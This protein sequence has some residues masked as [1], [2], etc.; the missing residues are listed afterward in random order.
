MLKPKSK[1]KKRE[2][3]LLERCLKIARE[4][5]GQP[6]APLMEDLPRAYIRAFVRARPGLKLVEDRA[7]NMLVK[8]PGRAGRRPPLVLVAH[9]DHPGFHVEKASRS[10]AR[11]AFKGGVAQA[12]AHSGLRVRFFNRGEA[13]PSG[14]GILAKIVCKR[15]RLAGA[16]ARLSAGRP[17]RGDF[18]LWDFPAFALKNGAI[19]SRGCDD[20]LGAAAALCVLDEL[21]GSTGFPACV[22][23]LF[24]RAE[25]FGFMGALEAIRLKTVPKNARIVSLECSK[26]L[27]DAP[28]GGGVI[29]RVGD[30]AGIFA[31]HLT[32][33]LH[34]AAQ[35]L[36]KTK[37]GFKS[38]RKLMDGGTCEA[39]IFCAYGYQASGLAVPLGNYHNQGFTPRGVATIK[40]EH[41]KVADFFNEIQL[42]LELARNPAWLQEKPGLP[43][44]VKVR[45]A[46][47]CKALGKEGLRLET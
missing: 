43:E 36:A 9:L 5:L 38:Q 22:Y 15:G 1:T 32:E 10:A 31:P 45:A 24:T 37:R 26:A 17:A 35:H 3:K 7:G 2:L 40:P 12:H 13:A 16:V 33:A 19:V 41:V 21:C 23:A 4:L 34:R 20:P 28:Q 46:N 11:L 44:W 6:A 39:T 29:V 27:A 30:K 14:A 25:E 18:A 8:L 47:A 42:L